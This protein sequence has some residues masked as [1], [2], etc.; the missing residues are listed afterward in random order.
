MRPNIEHQLLSLNRGF[1]QTF[2][3]P[4]AE[5][6]NRPQPGVEHFLSRVGSL[7]PVLD[8]GCGNGS[9][10]LALW[11]SGH[12]AAYLG[13]DN[14]ESLLDWAREHCRH[15]N[16]EFKLADLAKAGWVS[17]VPSIDFQWIFVLAVLHHLPGYQRRLDWAKA[18]G[19][20]LAPQNHVVISVW[21][22][23]AEARW[24]DRVVPWSEIGLEEKDVE[25]GDALLDWRRGGRGLRYVHHF[26]P[27]ELAKLADEA[28]C[29]VVEQQKAGGQSGQLNL[30]QLWRA[31]DR[32]D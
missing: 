14:S 12:R 7:Q 5:S 28:D 18:L 16:A 2:A 9:L 10:A 6:R 21:N 13:F 30:L 22:F 27:A 26:N 3:E 4:F 11:E 15:A 20:I 8:L 24:R 17:Q 19:T 23:P 29:E 1:Y 25:T 32:E 31:R